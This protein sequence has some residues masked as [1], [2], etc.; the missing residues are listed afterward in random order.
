MVVRAASSTTS[1]TPADIVLADVVPA[2]DLDLDVQAVVAQQDG[3]RL[4][5]IAAIADELRGIGQRPA[6]QASPADQL[7]GARRARCSATLS[8]L[9][10]SRPSCTA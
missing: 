10:T 4:G 8:K 1:A 2:V 3:A 9:T 7:R 5:R 6:S